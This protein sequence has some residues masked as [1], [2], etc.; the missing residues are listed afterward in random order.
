MGQQANAMY[1]HEGCWRA[2]HAQRNGTF[3]DW[4]NDCVWH[5]MVWTA[6]RHE[7]AGEAGTDGGD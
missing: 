1:A 4:R 2:E 3:G 7:A 5:D 6:T